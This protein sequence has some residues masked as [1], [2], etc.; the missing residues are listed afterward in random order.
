MQVEC[1]QCRQ[2]LEFADR[3]PAFCGFCGGSLSEAHGR[4]ATTQ[5]YVE[6][7]GYDSP[8]QAY[9]ADSADPRAA[10]A[11]LVE[12]GDSVGDYKLLRQL[13]QGGM[14]VVYEAE[15]AATGRRVALKLLS[16]RLVNT[17]D[18]M[19]R[20]V[21]EGRLAAAFSHPRS[22]F[23]F[24]A[25][26]HAG[27]PYITMELM[28]GRTLNDVCQDEGPLT[29]NRAVDY[30][31]DVIEGLA[32]A[33][34]A[35]V[36]H[37]DVKP[38][39]CFLDSDGRVKVGD[40][41]LSKSLVS[42]ADLT[43]TG[44]FLGTPLFAAPEQV[45]AGQIDKRTDIYSVGATLFYLIA[46]RGPFIGDPAAVIAQ[47]ASD[48]APSLRRL[49]P[50][51]PKDLDQIVARTLEK[52]AARRFADLAQLGDALQ[53]F[54]TGGL[55]A[56]PV[57]RRAAAYFVD[58]LVTGA[59]FGILICAVVFAVIFA[60]IAYAARTGGPKGFQ[61]QGLPVTVR[62]ITQS[63]LFYAGFV[64]LYFAICET[65]T[66]KSLGK[67]LLGLRVVGLDGG[68]PT[69]GRAFLRASLV[70]GVMLLIVAALVPFQLPADLNFDDQHVDRGRDLIQ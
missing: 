40:F 65:W 9:L 11:S 1:P 68:R 25:G 2:V 54:A 26:Q 41:G 22:T 18:S 62:Q 52:D 23:V 48:P 31:L 37:R 33:H 32:A 49:V 3:R 6:V 58:T 15:Q 13:G 51:V 69:I 29:V 7:A 70:P 30:I 64:V 56:A 16:P 45:R 44:A 35:G 17:D 50:S 55:A 60:Q 24:G 61:S 12:H 63:A 38:S 53:P 21:R 19:E 8:T 10:F 27:Q 67:R 59:A 57:G 34:A 43:R 14:G 66:G 20:F 28:P 42:D 36:I 47:I 5:A 39:N 46:G 4:L